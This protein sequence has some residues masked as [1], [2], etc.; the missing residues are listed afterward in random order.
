[1]QIPELY[2]GVDSKEFNCFLRFSKYTKILSKENPCYISSFSTEPISMYKPLSLGRVVATENWAVVNSSSGS[3]PGG[4]FSLPKLGRGSRTFLLLGRLRT[5]VSRIFGWQR[6]GCLFGDHFSK[7][8][9]REQFTN[10]ATIG[11]SRLE[12]NATTPRLRP[13]NWY[14]RMISQNVDLI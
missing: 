1:M 8:K 12:S 11:S 13:R 3:A 6:L 5:R 4:E 9:I 7:L 2:Y 14:S 10:H